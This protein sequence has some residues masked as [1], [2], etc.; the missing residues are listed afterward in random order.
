MS[1]RVFGFILVIFPLFK[2]TVHKLMKVKRGG[3]LSNPLTLASGD[4]CFVSVIVPLA[5]LAA[6]NASFTFMCVL[7]QRHWV[8][9]T[10]E[11]AVRHIVTANCQSPLSHCVSVCLAHSL[12]LSLSVCV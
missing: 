10:E 6:C 7:H 2:F 3:K 9:R 5:V 11:V 12:L 8:K 4:S 1:Q